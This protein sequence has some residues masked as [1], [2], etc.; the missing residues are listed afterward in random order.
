[1]ATNIAKHRSLWEV[2]AISPNADLPPTISVQVRT[3]K[4]AAWSAWVSPYVWT[5]HYVFRIIGDARALGAASCELTVVDA[6]K[7]ERVRDITGNTVIPS[8]QP[9]GGAASDSVAGECDLR[10]HTHSQMRDG[11]V[12]RYEAVF[13][14]GGAPQF[15]AV[16]PEFYVR[17]RRA[18]ERPYASK[19]D[20]AA[21]SA[22]ADEEAEC[23][24]CA[25][26]AAAADDGSPRAAL[27]ARFLTVPHELS[28]VE[29][30]DVCDA[31]VTA[32]RRAEPPARQQFAAALR[33]ALPSADVTEEEMLFDPRVMEDWGSG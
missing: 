29:A 6:W 17:A 22:S 31:L 15:K 11:A 24:A 19:A 4:T 26:S 30:F 1:M 7:A 12:F 23:R 20:K 5:C 13:S 32:F 33:A 27:F 14:T 10:F 18:R 3:K 21:E 2:G 28:F 8:F 16:S 25:A 9:F